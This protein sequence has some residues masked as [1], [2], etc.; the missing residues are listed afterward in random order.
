MIRKFSNIPCRTFPSSGSFLACYKTLGFFF[1]MPE[2]K[3]NQ[4]QGPKVVQTKWWLNGLDA[5]H[6]IR[7][8]YL[9]DEESE[10]REAS[11][12]A[13]TS[14]TDWTRCRNQHWW[15]AILHGHIGC[16]TLLFAAGSFWPGGG[17]RLG[18]QESALLS[19]SLSLRLSLK[20]K[21]HRISV[22]RQRETYLTVC[23]SADS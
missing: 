4:H 23:G 17:S 3:T 14:I 10:I 19:L 7:R 12:Q 18:R 11:V 13:R 2:G 20:N 5:Q 16:N 9:S 8:N 22:N 1:Q 15:K 6:W 21:E